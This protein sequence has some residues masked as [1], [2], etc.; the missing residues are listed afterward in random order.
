MV[1][2][3][4]PAIIILLV[5]LCLSGCTEA[6]EPGKNDASPTA[7]LR[8]SEPG[9]EVTVYNS[10]LGVVKETRKIA[11]KDG[12][13]E[14]SFEGVA[15]L[16]DPTSVKLT[17]QD[18]SFS[19]LEQNY[20]YDLADREK[21]LA[22]YLGK[23]I[24]GYKI[25]GQN[26]EPVEGKL[27]SASAGELTLEGA[28]GS[29]EIVPVADILLPSLPEGLTAKPTLQWLILGEGAGEK[30]AELSYMT[31]GMS[32]DADYVLVADKDDKTAGVN[33]WVTVTNN[34]GTT[35]KDA[36]LKLIAGDVNRV[37]EHSVPQMNM[38]DKMK[39]DEGG[40]SQ[41]QEQAL[42]EYHMYDLQRKTTLRDREQKQISL[43]TADSVAVD[44][45]YV[46]EGQGGWYYSGSDNTKVQ[47]KLNFKNSKEN[48]LGI[49]LPKGRVRVFKA[50]SE[51]KLQFLGEDQIDHTPKDE[52]LRILVGNAF[53]VVGE[54]KQM[55][56]NQLGSCMY[57][58]TWQDVLRNHKDADITVT[59]L[60]NAYWDWTI[61]DENYPHAKES[62]QKIKWSIPVKAGGNSTLTYKIRYRYC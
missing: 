19:I 28:N 35:F 60:E 51:G 42:F 32:W 5:M 12:V 15:S 8:P 54:R 11:V 26:K 2:S 53:D 48:G 45:E 9:I 61:T 56:V 4:A 20:R 25:L 17:S 52:T 40:G 18:G 59:V 57:D 16:I 10:D 7:P 24:S 29:I 47:V 31:S 46:Y 3:S 27:L 39:K 58:V 50:D 6:P 41:F 36:S 55:K 49:P 34:A 43:L 22:K 30:T 44:K 33:G 21:L 37:Q 1:D 23:R 14:Y 62:N 38:V 13:G